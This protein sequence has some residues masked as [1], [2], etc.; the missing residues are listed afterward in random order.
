[1]TPTVVQPEG[2]PPTAHDRTS[3]PEYTKA[4]IFA[5][6]AF[7]SLLDRIHAGEEG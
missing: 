1:M 6:A 2:A 3:M 5:V 7:A 4:K